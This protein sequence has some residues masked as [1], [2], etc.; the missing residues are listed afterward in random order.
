MTSNFRKE[1][2]GPEPGER[3]KMKFMHSHK[4]LSL[5]PL[6]CV[7]K[8]H[9]HMKFSRRYDKY[10]IDS[11]RP[12][13]KCRLRQTGSEK[14]VTLSKILYLLTYRPNIFLRDLP[15]TSTILRYSPPVGDPQISSIWFSRSTFPK[16]SFPKDAV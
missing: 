4:F 7:A 16:I 3:L 9:F 15:P 5:Y 1:T 6:P 8:N 11:Y 10:H 13:W 14:D 12:V 2:L